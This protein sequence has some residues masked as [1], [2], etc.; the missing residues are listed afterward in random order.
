MTDSFAARGN[1]AVAGIRSRQFGN[2]Q[3]IGAEVGEI[4]VVTVTQNAPRTAHLWVETLA[5][6]VAKLQ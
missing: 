6:Q 3:V 1:A 4:T 5:R 2:Y